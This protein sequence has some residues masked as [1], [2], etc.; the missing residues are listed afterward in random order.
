MINIHDRMPVILPEEQWDTG[1]DT[2]N[3]DKQAL[4][5]LLTQYP[6]EE[7]TAWR[8]GTGVNTRV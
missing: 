4:Q 1:L 7:M 6:H 8:V 2:A 5:N 3:T